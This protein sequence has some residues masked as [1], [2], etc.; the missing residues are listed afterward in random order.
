MS[1]FFENAFPSRVLVTDSALR[2]VIE[3]IVYNIEFHCAVPPSVAGQLDT[4]VVTS[5][6]LSGIRYVACSDHSETV[7]NV[8]ASA[9]KKS[10]DVIRQAVASSAVQDV[11]F[12]VNINISREPAAGWFSFSR[13]TPIVQWKF[14][15]RRTASDVVVATGA[16]GG[17]PADA[18]DSVKGSSVSYLPASSPNSL[19]LANDA[20]RLREMLIY[21]AD[22]SFDSICTGMI[23]ELVDV[24]KGILV[25]DC[26]VEA[27]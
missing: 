19:Q 15:F 25:Y 22:K 2:S 8:I 26:T 14:K 9:L 5:S 10:Q 24:K 6:D 23:S 13:K 11:L 18:Q 27:R 17:N 20:H 4:H 12:T 7:R 21:I 1:Q 3:A 16:V